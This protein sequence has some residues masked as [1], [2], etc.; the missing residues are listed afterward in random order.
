MFTV[1]NPVQ[2][3]NGSMQLDFYQNVM[4]QSAAQFQQ[5]LTGANSN[6]KQTQPVITQSSAQQ[7]IDSAAALPA[8]TIGV[9]L[10]GSELGQRIPQRMAETAYGDCNGC[11]Q[12][13]VQQALEDMNYSKD[14]MRSLELGGLVDAYSCISK[15]SAGVTKNYAEIIAIKY[16]ILV[17]VESYIDG[18]HKFKL[19]LPGYDLSG[20]GYGL[21]NPIG[22]GM[23]NPAL[24]G[25]L[26][27]VEIE[28]DASNYGESVVIIVRKKIAKS[29]NCGGYEVPIY[30]KEADLIFKDKE[31]VVRSGLARLGTIDSNINE[32]VTAGM[33]I[34]KIKNNPKLAEVAYRL[35]MIP[36]VAPVN[37]HNKPVQ[38][39]I[40]LDG[41]DCVCADPNAQYEPISSSV[42]SHSFYEDM[43]PGLARL[44]GV[45]AKNSPSPSLSHYAKS[46]MDKDDE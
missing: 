35:E 9:S 37:N 44:R 1:M 28:V 24:N 16:D 38:P 43:D 45:S 17:L 42:P 7:V 18:V 25:A 15:N 11:K 31:S 10:N 14:T 19:A 13:E 3:P 41:R 5:N 12:Y 26:M 40:P 2:N 39:M 4:Q 22:Y 6:I 46:G 8:C 34:E 33:L 27:S 30:G 23:D 20:S 29:M 32:S 21:F 36:S